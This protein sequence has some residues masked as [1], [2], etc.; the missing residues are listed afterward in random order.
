MTYSPD[1][2]FDIATDRMYS[3]LNSYFIWKWINLSINTNKDGAEKAYDNLDQVVNKYK[4]FFQQTLVNS[5]NSFIIDL[6]IFFDKNYDEVFTLKKLTKAVS[7]TLTKEV[8]QKVENLIKPN[9]ETINLVRQL[10][11]KV[12]HAS[13][14]D[15]PNKFVL[16]E[17]FEKLFAAL[18][19]VI[20]LLS[21]THDGSVTTWNHVEK[22]VEAD[23]SW[24]FANLKRGE[25]ER[26]KEIHNK[27]KVEIALI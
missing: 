9:F 13:L 15:I 12:A 10:R 11:N 4:Y 5:F 23:L 14:I 2:L 16:Y 1:Q 21:I 25:N 22:D 19:E 7:P 17:S 8:L 24:I 20:N 27:Y 3:I 6:A 18:H 26:I